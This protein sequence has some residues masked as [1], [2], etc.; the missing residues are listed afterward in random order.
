MCWSCF[1][2]SLLF[3]QTH[4]LTLQYVLV[5]FLGFSSVLPDASTYSPVCVGLVFRFLF[6]SSRRIHLLSSMCWS[7]FQV[8]LLSFQTHP[9][10]L[11]YV[12]VLFLGFSS[13]LPDASTYSPVCAGLVFRFLF[14]PSGRIHLLSSM[15]WSCFQVSLLSFQTHPLTLQ[16]VLVLFLGFSSVLP[17]ASTYSPVCAGLVFRFLFCP[18]GRIHLLSS[19]CWSCFQVSLLSFQTHP[20]TLQFVLVLF[21]GFSSVLPD[22]STYSPV[23]A[24]LVFR[25]LF[26]PSRRIH[27]LSSMCWSCFQVSLL[28]FQTHPLTLQYVLVLF[29]GFSSVLPDASTYSPVCAGLVFRFLFCPSRRIHLL[30]SMCWS[31]FQ[32]S[33]LS[34]QTHPL[35]L[36]YVLVLFLGFSSVLPD[37]STYS[38]VCAGLVF[39][40]LFCPS[41]R[42][43]LLSSMCWSCFQV[44]LLSFQTHPLTLQYVLVLFLGFSSVLPDAFTYSPVC[45]GLVFR[46]LFCPSRRIHLLS[47]MCWSCFQVSL[48]SFQTHPLT[49]QYVLVLFLGFSSVLPDASTYSPVCAGLVFRFLF[50]PSRRIHLLSSMCWSCFQV[51]L[52]FFQT[53]PLT[54]QY[55]LVLFLGFSSVLPDASTYSPVCVGLVFRFLFCP[56]RRIHL[57][58]SMCWSCFQ[59][60]LLSF[61][62][63]PLTLQFV[64]VLFL[65]FS[66]VLPDASTYSPVCAGLVFRFLFCPSRRIH[67]LSSMCW[68]CFQVSLLFFQTHPLTLQYVL[69]LFLGFSSVLPDASTYSPVCAGLVFRFL[70]CPSR[71]IHLLSSMCW[72]CFQVSLLSFQTHPLTLQ[73]VLVLFLGFSSVLPDASTYSPV[74]AGLVFRFLFCSSRRIHLLSSMCWSCFQVSLLSFQTHPLTL[75]YVL[76]LFLGFSSVLPDASTYSP[77]C[78]GLVFRFLFCPSRRIHLLSSMCWSCFQVSLLS[79][80]THPLTLQYVLVLFLGFSS[81]LPDASTYSP[82]CA[83]LVFRFLFCPSRRIHLLSSMCWSCFQVSLLSFQTHPLTLQYV[84]VLFLGFSSVL[85]DASTYSPVCAGLVFRFLFCSSRRIHLLSSMCWSCFQVSLLSFQTHPLTLQYVLVL[86]LGFSSVLPDAFTYSPVCV[87]LVFR[88]LFRPSRRI[89]LLSSMC[90]SCFQVS[91]LS[92]QTHPLTLQYVLVLFL[93]FSSVLPD[94]STYSPVC[95]GLVFR[96]LFCPSRRI[97]LLSSMCWSCFQVSLLSFQTH[98]LTLQY[99]LVLFLGF[100]SVLPDASTYSP[101]CVG[102]VFR[103]LFCPSRRIHLLSSMCWSCFQVSLLFFQT[104]PLTLQYVLVLFLGFSSVL[105][106]ASTYS[107][108][109][110]WSCFQVSLLSFQTHPLTLQYVLVLF[111]GFS[112]VFQTH[113]LFSSMCWSCFQVSL[114]S[115]ETHP[116]YSPVCVGLVFRFLFCSFQTHSTYSPVCVGLV[117]RFSSV[118]SRRIHLLSSMCWSC[119]QVSLLFFQTHSLTLQYVLVLFQVLFCLP[120]AFTYSPVCVGLVFRFLFCPSRHI[121]LLSSMCWSCFQVTGLQEGGFYQFRVFAAGIVGLGDASEP[122]ELFLCER[123]TMPEPGKIMHD[124]ERQSYGNLHVSSVIYFH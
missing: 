65:G 40:F 77:V 101:V 34:F 80:Q 89:H 23:C 26:C 52:L 123:W 70:F 48:L 93:G 5:L 24:G 3:F 117:F 36:Q 35:T 66:S 105:P 13:V 102:L 16:Y 27:L 39:R 50:C 19:M 83:G 115:S 10:T 60:S 88:F 45:A 99:V 94:A 20:L 104:H 61:Q 121:H 110:A 98:P 85:P 73:Y 58:S 86:F 41:R 42:I 119:F 53:H 17:D 25:F 2:V 76:V 122:S 59:V 21:L 74:C 47:S 78:A 30:S 7:C 81:V 113:P 91:L 29:L 63:H 95:A 75:Q 4:P 96:F 118:P 46:F 55:V 1:Q 14:C 51:S 38:P 31:C 56:S 109:C 6:C 111:L 108:V 84:L 97:H 69:V 71:R 103:F 12:L 92:F 79:F 44:S 62:T 107:P 64:L 37:A 28:F 15:C 72:S 67:L 8:S 22:A 32:V 82:V 100:S 54:L 9:L 90:W 114:C 116:L 11:Q 33:L 112:S 57:L 106:D 49:L 87:G 68:S 43:H 120:D 124:Q 18:S